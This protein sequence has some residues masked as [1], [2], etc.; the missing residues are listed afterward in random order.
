MT[1]FKHF[2]FIYFCIAVGKWFNLQKF[3]SVAN[4]STPNDGLL[5]S[6]MRTGPDWST[7]AFNGAPDSQTPVSVFDIDET[8]LFVVDGYDD[9]ERLMSL[10]EYIP[11]EFESVM[12]SLNIKSMNM[13]GINFEKFSLR[14]TGLYLTAKG[15]RETHY[16]E[17]GKYSLNTWDTESL[18]VLQPSSISNLRIITLDVLKQ[19][20]Y[21]TNMDSLR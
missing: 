16:L 4:V 19:E 10:Y 2:H 9:L 3:N 20:L 15:N 12:N 1:A 11:A 17:P 8:E 14:Y 7:R 13:V 18:V 5:A 21:P 6:P